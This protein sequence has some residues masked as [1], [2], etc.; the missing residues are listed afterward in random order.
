MN[1]ESWEEQK[2]EHDHDSQSEG[3]S[4]SCSS[5]LSES[6][7]HN[8]LILKTDEDDPSAYAKFRPVDRYLH[9]C[10][11]KVT[12]SGEAAGYSENRHDGLRQGDFGRWPRLMPF[13]AILR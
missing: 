8:N 11:A 10:I 2:A 13:L 6:A 7:E 5:P 12:A 4:L 9:T 1:D 3:S